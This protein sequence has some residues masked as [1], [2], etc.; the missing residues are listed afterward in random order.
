[1][2]KE[3]VVNEIHKAAR[4]NFIRRSVSLRG[5]DDLWQADLID[6]QSLKKDNQGYK[7]IL[8]VLDCFSKFSWA[9]PVKTKSK[10][11]VSNAFNKILLSSNRTPI[12][13]QTDMGTEFYNNEFKNLTNHNKINHY[14][15][16]SIKK[17]S[18]VE[19]L[20]KT[21]KNKIYK[22]F[23]LNGS[24]KWIGKPLEDIVATY[25]NT[26]HRTTKYKPINVNCS[27]EHEVRRNITTSQVKN[28][29]L[30]KKNQLSAGDLVRIS[31]FKGG[32]EKG[33]T[34][35]WSTEI[36]LIRKVN[37][38]TPVTY[39]IEDLHK[40][41]V[42]GTFYRQELQKTK[43]PDIYLIEKVIRRK[44]TKLFVK[45]LGLPESENSWIEKRAL[46]K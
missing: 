28:N 3:Q 13:L 24:Y 10:F 37:Q 4:K 42:L 32:F 23:S 33:Y 35:N 26:L 25:N 7:Y 41:P 17:A 2:S 27:N 15:T 31:K 11:E 34:P 5:I 22:Y 46:L 8:V 45:W 44:G 18:I 9:V 29:V 19:R 40:R 20:I 43:C 16:Y 21:I 30:A 12:N 14:S 6:F 36:F 39:V 1:M 38:S